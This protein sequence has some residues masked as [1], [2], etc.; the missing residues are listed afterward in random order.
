MLFVKFLYLVYS[1]EIL[2]ICKTFTWLDWKEIDKIRSFIKKWASIYKEK[3]MYMSA[4]QWK[5]I[6]V[7]NNGT[8]GIILVCLGHLIMV[9][10]FRSDTAGTYMEYSWLKWSEVME[11]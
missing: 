7:T 6:M 3:Y 2:F 4:I 10:P 5:S 11:Q 9:Y 8:R 1:L